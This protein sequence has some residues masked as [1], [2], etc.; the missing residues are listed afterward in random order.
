M[1]NDLPKIHNRTRI[2]G[3]MFEVEVLDLEFSNG[4]TRQFRRMVNNGHGAV[5]IVAM[6]DEDNALLIREYAAGVH[7][8]ETGLPQG[9]IDEGEVALQAANRELK[10]EAGYGARDLR[11]INRLSMSPAYMSLVTD[12]VLAR[13]LYPERLPGDEPEEI[14]TFSWPLAKLDELAARED[15]TE[16]RSIAALYLARDYLNKER[17]QT[18]HQQ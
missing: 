14:E 3:G 2:P 18:G 12:V 1:A 16:G 17:N 6:L 11:V 13:D 8:Y 4:A 10:E 15:V 5:I 9:R 7:R